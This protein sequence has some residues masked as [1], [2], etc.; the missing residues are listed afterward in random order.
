[1]HRLRGD[2]KTAVHIT[3]TRC[4]CHFDKA[5]YAYDFTS[6]DIQSKLYAN[7]KT[8]VHVRELYTSV[9]NTDTYVYIMYL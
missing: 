9:N 1:M 4:E 2:G 5:V 3:V 7:I 6:H 8:H